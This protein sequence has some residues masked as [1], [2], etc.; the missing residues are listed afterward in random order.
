MVIAA[1]GTAGHVVPALAVAAALAEHDAEVS[2]AGTRDG[3]EARLVPAAGYEIDFVD[4]AGIDRRNPLRAALA[5]GRA[6]A[7][8]RVARRYLRSRGADAVLGGGGYVAAPTGIAAATMGI[9]L[10]LTEADSHLGLAN[11]LLAPRARRV[12]LALPIPGRGGGRYLVTGRP[13]PAAIAT[14][15]SGT[16]RQ[17][18]AIPAEVPCL[19]IFGGSLGAL[20]INRAAAAAFGP[21]G[22]AAERPFHVLHIAGARDYSV[23]APELEGA[24]AYTL[25]EYLPDLADALAASDLVLSRAGGS[26]FELTAA[27]RPAVLVPYP[28]ASGRHQHANARWMEQAG[29]ATIVEDEELDAE[30]LLAEV[31]PLLGDR[32]RLDAMGAAA[33]AIA[34]P[35]AADRVAA[36]IAAAVAD[37]RRGGSLG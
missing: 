35:D 23:V 22:P 29:A 36:E 28:Y 18:F 9:P 26:V 27:G 17:R 3:A 13:V 21:G 20:R 5:L 16:A 11:R 12:C 33:R 4:V 8:V 14:A 25:L 24:S 1:G 31:G 19:L 32:A 2:F 37:Q 10:V 7:A 15:D 30:R 34:R 6:A